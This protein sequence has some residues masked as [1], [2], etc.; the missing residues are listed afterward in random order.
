MSNCPCQ[1]AYTPSQEQAAMHALVFKEFGEFGRSTMLPNYPHQKI[2][3]FRKLQ[4]KSI[5]FGTCLH[6]FWYHPNQFG[7]SEYLH[8]GTSYYIPLLSLSCALDFQF[9]YSQS[10][11]S[12]G[13]LHS[14]VHATSPMAQLT[15]PYLRHAHKKHEIGPYLDDFT[16]TNHSPSPLLS[17]PTW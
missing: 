11:K 14:A 3:N 10:E 5:Y 12:I 8:M 1:Q 13:A 15:P 7:I 9:S 17:S 16:P 6:L 4:N 2:I